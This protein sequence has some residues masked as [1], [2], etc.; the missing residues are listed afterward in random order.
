MEKTNE[1]DKDNKEENENENKNELNKE[2]KIEI[3]KENE[4]ENKNELNKENKIENKEENENKNELNKENK[5][6]TNKENQNETNKE[7]E[8]KD[9]MYISKSE[10]IQGIANHLQYIIKGKG[11]S[12]I[13]KRRY[14]DFYQLRA[15]LLL[16]WPG[17]YIPNI[18][19]KKKVSELNAKKILFRIKALNTFLY[20]ISKI[21]YLFESEEMK[22]FQNVNEDFNKV[23]EKIPKLNEAQI[24]ENY[25]KSF[26]DYN[27][28][29]D[30]VKGKEN[31]NSFN[32][33]LNKIKNNL[34]SMKNSIDEIS[35][36]RNEDMINY[37]NLNKFFIVYDKNCILKYIDD[38]NEEK[39]IF[40]NNKNEKIK[41]GFEKLNELLK[42]PFDKVYLWIYNEKKDVDAMIEA[43]NSINNLELNY[44]KLKQKNDNI[45]NDIKKIENGSGFSFKGLFKKKD[46][47]LN[48][49]KQEKNKN[50]NNL[51]I[52]NEI[53]KISSFVMNNKI[54]DFKN[55]KIKNYFEIVK[56][57]A[58]NQIENNNKLNELFN[59]VKN[60]LIEIKESI[61]K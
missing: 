16:N 23:C 11:I 30:F 4:N 3:N 24:L 48:E 28:N 61:K 35:E 33:F 27:D 17:I 32:L 59:E 14:N 22:C 58:Q 21:P 57:F 55:Q 36:K 31:I 9:Y 6:E 1:N 25:K 60:L 5:I 42:N 26:T 53:I 18:P 34:N 41:N 12:D 52:I 46:E 38:K 54:N 29:F 51:N 45:E 44:N 40:N 50:D 49:L 8:E 37:L 20:N 56:V 19:N 43:I 47:L 10:L 7:N 39:L 13:I 2:N 15:K